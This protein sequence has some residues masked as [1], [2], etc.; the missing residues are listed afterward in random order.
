MAGSHGYFDYSSSQGGWVTKPHTQNTPSSTIDIRA[1]ADWSDVTNGVQ[2]LFG[3][4][5]S[6]LGLRT[7]SGYLLMHVYRTG[8]TYTAAQSTIIIDSTKKWVRAVIDLTTGLVDFYTSTDVLVADHSQVSWTSHESGLDTSNT[9]SFYSQGTVEGVWGVVNPSTEGQSHDDKIFAGAVLFDGTVVSELSFNV[10]GGNDSGFRTSSSTPD[11]V[12]PVA[13]TFTPGTYKGR[14]VKGP[15]RY[16]L[17][18]YMN[19]RDVGYNVI[20]TG[21]VASATPGVIAPETDTLAA[22]D[23]GS[24]EGGKAWY[25]G[26]IT[27]SVN[28]TESLHLTTAGYTTT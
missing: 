28:G 9:T 10:V 13:W 3:Y 8:F 12:D 27:Y 22:A 7:N 6:A 4:S 19:W 26:G 16:N 20:T 15:Q 1:L 18:R 25:R 14:I 24:G 23:S 17:W 11:Y 5:S 21:G 2:A